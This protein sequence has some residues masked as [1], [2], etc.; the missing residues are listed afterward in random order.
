[1]ERAVFD[2]LPREALCFGANLH[3]PRSVER[4]PSRT[5]SPPHGIEPRVRPG[6]ETHPPIDASVRQIVHHPAKGRYSGILGA[7]HFHENPYLGEK[8]RRIVPYAGN[9]RRCPCSAC[10]HLRP[11]TGIDAHFKG[12]IGPSVV[13]HKLAVHP[14]L[15][16]NTHSLEA[17]KEG[18]E[19]S[20]GWGRLTM[21]RCL[22][23]GQ[24]TR[25]G[26]CEL[27][28]VFSPKYHR[29]AAP[30]GKSL[31]IESI[32]RRADHVV[33]QVNW[34]PGGGSVGLGSAPPFA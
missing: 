2:R 12:S 32:E 15:T 3:S 6:A 11:Q 5:R 29:I 4:I 8:A 27:L 31:L 14:D 9:A 25:Y 30:A 28:Y 1:M 33:R 24:L 16:R 17:Q 34:S 18:R 7:V 19:R 23:R 10:I 21:G 20:R 13:P 22:I 26:A